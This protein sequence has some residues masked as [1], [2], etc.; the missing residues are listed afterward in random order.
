[1]YEG[2]GRL[3]H[4]TTKVRDDGIQERMAAKKRVIARAS[5]RDFE[6]VGSAWWHNLRRQNA[7]ARTEEEK[8]SAEAAGGPP[9]LF[10]VRFARDSNNEG[11]G[12]G[13]YPLWLLFSYIITA[14]FSISQSLV[15]ASLTIQTVHSVPPDH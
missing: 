2:N 3:F 10:Q 12:F 14:S 13:S 6:D 8:R 9:K 15:S 4:G 11:Y 5:M 1:M 7:E